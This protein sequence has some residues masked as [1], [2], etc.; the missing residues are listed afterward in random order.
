MASLNSGVLLLLLRNMNAAFTSAGEFPSAN[1]VAGGSFILQVTGIV[2]ALAG[3]ELFPDR[4]FYLQVSDSSHS[5]Y[6]CLPPGHDDL[7]LSDSVQ[8]G[9]LI[10]VH[11]LEASSPVPI[12]HG[13]RL[14]PGRHPCS[15]GTTFITHMPHTTCST[16]CERKKRQPRSSSTIKVE[17]RKPGYGISCGRSFPASPAKRQ[18]LEKGFPVRAELNKISLTCINEGS[19][20]SD[21]YSAVTSISS[22]PPPFT[23]TMTR[24]KT[25]RK[26]WEPAEKMKDK[27]R[28]TMAMPILRTRSASRDFSHY[29]SYLSKDEALDE[30]RDGGEGV[31]SLLNGS[32]KRKLSAS[33]KSSTKTPPSLIP[34]SAYDDVSWPENN[35]LWGSLSSNL[36]KY[37]KEVLKQR[38]LALC[39][40]LDA[41][42]EA[43]ALERLIRCLSTYSELKVGKDRDPQKVVDKFLDF[44]QD[45]SSATTSAQMEAAKYLS[46]RRKCAASWVKAALQSELSRSPQTTNILPEFICS[47]SP[48]RRIQSLIS[49]Q[50]KTTDTFPRGNCSSMAADLTKTLQSECNRWFLRY[51]EKFLDV[52]QSNTRYTEN[53]SQIASLLCQLKRVDE[54]LATVAGKDRAWLA[55]RSKECILMEED[56]ADACSRVRRKIYDILL[57]HVESAATALGKIRS[58]K[59]DNVET[60]GKLMSSHFQ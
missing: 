39:S 56:D 12:L 45:L 4:G 11:R 28:E 48:D 53:E 54:W 50:R 16:F 10:Q 36:V 42:M 43:C 19:D 6:V 13:L 38:D 33:S 2:P 26:I 9:Q 58:T 37:G 7:I 55:D 24:P 34:L 60:R 14:L 40:A 8:L 29:G 22:S 5:T 23:S 41:V 57:R 1:G 15:S 52:V 31:K 59:E 25:V 21:A 3:S 51:I 46:E 30:L 17:G 18:E 35:V 44:H 47:S 49:R 20:E 32:T 27:K